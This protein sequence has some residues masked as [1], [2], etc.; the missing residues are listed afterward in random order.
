M[1]FVPGCGYSSECKKNEIEISRYN[2]LGKRNQAIEIN[3]EK[4]IKKSPLEIHFWRVVE[5]SDFELDVTDIN[6]I[7]S[8]EKTTRDSIDGFFSDDW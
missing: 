2:I 7:G 3:R 4:K 8:K 5:K 6:E 1:K